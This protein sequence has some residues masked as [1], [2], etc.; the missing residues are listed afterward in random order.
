MRYALV[1]FW[2]FATCGLAG[3]AGSATETTVAIGPWQVEASF[4]DERKFDRCVMTRPASGGA[5][6]TFTRDDGGLSLMLTQPRCLFEKGV[7]HSA[8]FF[9]GRTPRGDHHSA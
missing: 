9:G 5:E 7:T 3:A 8:G 2:M 1:A 6:A 4:T